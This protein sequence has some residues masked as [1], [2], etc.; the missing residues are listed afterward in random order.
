MA[1]EFLL[2]NDIH[3]E[4]KNVSKDPEA[5]REMQM[6][7]ISGVPSFLIG[8]DV[9]VGLD[10]TRILQLVDHRLAKCEKCSQKLRVPTRKGSIQITCPKCSH[11]FMTSI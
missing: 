8:E 6:R 10:K 7:N 11:K 5:G 4:E 1:K 9:V 2:H 3:F